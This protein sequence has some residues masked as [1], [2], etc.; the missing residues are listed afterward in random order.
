[1]DKINVNIGNSL[2]FNQRKYTQE[3]IDWF[4]DIENKQHYKFIMFDI[5]DFTRQFRRNS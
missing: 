2:L 1:M 5:K 3:V 4:K